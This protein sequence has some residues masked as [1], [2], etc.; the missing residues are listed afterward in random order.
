MRSNSSIAYITLKPVIHLVPLYLHYIGFETC[1]SGLFRCSWQKS[2][3]K[4]I[5]QKENVRRSHGGSAVTNLTST[6]EDASLIPGLTQWVKD[7]ALQQAVAQIWHCYGCG[8][9]HWLHMAPIQPWLL[10]WEP[11]YAVGVV[12]KRQKKKKK[13]FENRERKS[14]CGKKVI[15]YIPEST[16]IV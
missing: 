6:H 11:S 1:L 8:V 13:R 2:N 14:Y 10:A 16:N 5:K 7:A 15:F 4:C 3:L 9:G 12:L